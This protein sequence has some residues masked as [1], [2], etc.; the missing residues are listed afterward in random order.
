ME[1]QIRDALKWFG[2][3]AEPRDCEYCQDGSVYFG[4]TKIIEPTLK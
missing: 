4:L 3:E 2:I 1:D